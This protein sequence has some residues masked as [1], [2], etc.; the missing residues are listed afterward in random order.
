[1]RNRQ[2]KTDNLGGGRR[3]S[4]DKNLDYLYLESAMDLLDEDFEVDIDVE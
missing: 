3:Y 2:K 1:M 4:E